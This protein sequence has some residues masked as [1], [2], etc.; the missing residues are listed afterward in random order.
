MNVMVTNALSPMRVIE[1][2]QDLVS[3]GGLIGAMS[4]GQGSISNNTTAMREL[5]RG[6]KAALNMFMRSFAVR[7]S[8]TARARAHR[9]S[10]R[11]RLSAAVSGL[12]M[13][14]VSMRVWVFVGDLIR[15][16]RPGDEDAVVALSLRAWAPVFRSLER[17]LGAEI[18]TRLH[19]DW[20]HDQEG[21]VRATLTDKAMRVWVAEAEG[22][23]VGFAAATLH[24]DRGIGEI[25]MLAV[26]PPGQNRGIGAGL[27]EAATRWLG[28]SGMIVAMID[29][30]GDEGHAPAR[31]VYEQRG[32]TP[33]P[34]ARYFKAL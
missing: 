17:L 15:E 23:V 5:Y 2:L 34:V 1:S 12:I 21:A 24:R 27:V 20:R 11:G 22:G 18:F 14:A 10:S 4:S 30:G 31:R 28:D 32:Y 29:T 25:H 3:P 16:Y 13:Q 6:S 7:Q 26:D 8:G 9:M 19:P 33:L